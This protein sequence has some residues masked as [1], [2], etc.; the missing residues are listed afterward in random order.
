MTAPV[1]PQSKP[2][3]VFDTNAL[4]SAA[5]LPGSTSGRAL[6][7]AIAHFQLA[8]STPVIEELVKVLHRPRL[9]RYFEGD[10]MVDFLMTLSRISEIIVPTESISDCRDP[11]DNMLL[12]LAVA[13]QARYLI[14]GDKDLL[15]LHLF[16]GIEILSAG[17][18]AARF[19]EF[20][21]RP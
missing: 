6:A 3:I 18:L 20:A 7:W 10:A 19:D 14:S 17:V 1:K 12:E 4:A 13:A 16:R 5:I 9:A 21:E 15:V 11:K 2:R 8:L